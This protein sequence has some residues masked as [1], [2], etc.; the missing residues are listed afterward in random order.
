MHCCGVLT[1][2][3]L[4]CTQEGLV[5]F[6]VGVHVKGDIT[7][8]VWFGHHNLGRRLHSRPAFAYAFHTGFIQGGVERMN[9][10]VLDISN[11]LLFPADKAGRFFMDMTL[12]DAE[13]PQEDQ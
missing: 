3:P 2:L 1:R 10:R 7:V 8:G 13:S 9:I 11:K 5:P 4:T 12:D 6:S